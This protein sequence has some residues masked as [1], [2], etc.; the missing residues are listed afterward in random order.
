MLFAGSWRE[1]ARVVIGDAADTVTLAGFLSTTCE[2]R[3]YLC[4]LRLRRVVAAEFAEPDTIALTVEYSDSTGQQFRFGP[5]C[6]EEGPPRTRAPFL[7]VARNGG[8]A[9]ASLPLYLP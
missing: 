6:G 2:R 8:F 7:T 9:A 5:C 1:S 3:F 4:D